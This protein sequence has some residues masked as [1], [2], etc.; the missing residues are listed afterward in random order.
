VKGWGT[1]QHLPAWRVKRLTDDDEYDDDDDDDDNDDMTT[2]MMSNNTTVKWQNVL[3]ICVPEINKIGGLGLGL[4]N[5][6]E[7]GF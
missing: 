7:G 6:S 5:A 2:T 1:V 3:G 4:N